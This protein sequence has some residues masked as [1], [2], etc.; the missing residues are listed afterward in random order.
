M[1]GNQVT[2]VE[3]GYA[4]FDNKRRLSLGRYVEIEPGDYALV[5]RTAEG[6]L[7]ITPVPFPKGG[8]GE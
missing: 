8:A 1:E 5:Q 2:L 3:A 4:R 7:I 6:E